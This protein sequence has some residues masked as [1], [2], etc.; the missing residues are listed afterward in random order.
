MKKWEFHPILAYLAIALLLFVSLQE[1]GSSATRKIVA[2][3]YN[4]HQA[5]TP[6]SHIVFIVQENHTFDSLFGLFPGA[7]GTSTGVIKVNGQDQTIPLNAM[8]DSETNFSHAWNAA[9]EDADHGKMDA[10]NLGEGHGASSNR[11]TGN[12]NIA[13]YPCY[14]E[15][16]QS[17]IPNYWA[18]A[19]HYLLSDNT[20][21]SEESASF[22]NHLYTVAAG[23]GP[24]IDTSAI[25]NP[26]T[27]KGG[28]TQNWGCDAETGTVV[29][30]YNKKEVY[31]C[32]SYSTIMQELDAAQVSWRYYTVTK[33]NGPGH[34]W[35][36]PDAFS[37]E[38]GNQNIVSW[39]HFNRDVKAG[40]LPSV[41]WLTGP[42]PDS[43]HPPASLC[44]GEN[45]AVNAINAVEKSS[46]Y[47]QNTAIVLVWDDYGGFYDHVAPPIVDKLGLGFR[48]PL[49]LISP[50]AYATDNPSDPHV[51]HIQLEFSSVLK[52]IEED[53]NLPSLGRRDSTANSISGLFNF[54][55][56]NPIPPLVLHQRKCSPSSYH[57]KMTGDWN[58]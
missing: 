36:T 25:S 3:G 51:S 16:N 53:F 42:P 11:A 21:S 5:T 46:L 37:Y 14:V 32:W 34:D 26:L 56:S 39:M 8:K 19:Q 9:H 47:N 7:N 13:P 48:V 55:T 41:S 22:D 43:D 4:N 52:F 27:P 18:Y 54:S 12:C 50:Y 2:A 45:W 1:Q 17:L 10:F 44:V 38:T 30:L 57:I 6:V 33:T 15:A 20:Y 29:T 31:P 35:D 40:N 24:T 58:D 28:N 23:S 49:I